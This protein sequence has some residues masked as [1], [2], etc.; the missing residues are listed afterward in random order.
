M[1]VIRPI[2]SND[3]GALMVMAQ[4]SGVGFT[5]LPVN[6]ALLQRKI[7]HSIDSFEQDVK[8][9]GDQG[10]LMVAEDT[11][12]G[13]IIGTTAIEAAVGMNA[14]FY[15][16]HVGKVVHSSP[17]LGVYNLVEILT[18]SNDYTGVS[19][20]CTLFL[21][22]PYRSSHAGRLLSR[23]RFLLMA[24]H[25][26]RFAATVIAEMRGVSDEDGRSPFWVWLEQNFFSVDFPTVDHLTGLGNKQFIAELM[27]KYPIYISLLSPQAQKVIG[28][29]HEKTLPALKLLEGEGFHKNGYIDIFDAGPT[30]ECPIEHI[31]SVRDCLRLQ[32]EIGA[33]ID[34]AEYI[35]SNISC[36][37]F[38]ATVASMSVS[39][40]HHKAVLNSDVAEALQ[41]VAGDTVR[42]LPL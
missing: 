20:L 5:S 19:E 21:R 42:V 23:C 16:Y 33:P 36:R 3:L 1:L 7:T 28:Q 39:L 30:V 17:T 11:T 41:V 31:R 34:Q 13:E 22:E 14:P 10:Y 24:E 37:N 8:Q 4:E 2:Q 25:R 6:E 29:V 32:V 12:R 26:K 40:K 18:L 9:P 27:P 38:R 35:V 15:N